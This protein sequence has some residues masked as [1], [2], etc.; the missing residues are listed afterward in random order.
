MSKIDGFGQRPVEVSGGS[1]T[2]GPER[3]GSDKGS[4]VDEG[5]AADRVTL[6]ESARLLQRLSEAIANAP[7]SDAPR[8]QAL[9]QAIARGEYR[10]DPDKVA[11]KL[12]AL[13][14]DLVGR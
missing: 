1:R 12:I 7:E 13:E 5:R 8:I 2:T 11:A 14:R 9:K 6:T 10:T 3:A 4:A